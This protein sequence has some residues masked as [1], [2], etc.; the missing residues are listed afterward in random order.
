[1]TNEGS[2]SGQS[3][4][5]DS[6]S[7]PSEP[8]SGGYEAP[9]IENAQQPSGDSPPAYENPAYDPPQQYDAPPQYGTPSYEN[10]TYGSPSAD[11][12]HPGADPGYPQGG[13]PPPPPYGAAPGYPPPG[14]PQGQGY[15][16]PPGYGQAPGY[17]AQ[18][19]GP[20]PGY[21]AP[22][23]GGPGYGGPGYGEQSQKT[24]SLAIYS[25][26]ASG[27]GV[28][29]GIGSIIGIA[30]GVIALNQ[31]KQNPQN[32]RNLA[33]AGIAVG[34]VSLLISLLLAGTMLA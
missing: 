2:H 10:P 25:L 18:G 27:I 11:P 15:G 32:G 20:P 1:M 23:Y 7:G 30:L 33:I 14:Y 28:L 24:N 17:G 22:G 26:V 34:A 13:Y 6:G 9:G 19:Y 8:T 16:Q 5:P 3:S 4:S 21:G 12:V 31:I 29:C